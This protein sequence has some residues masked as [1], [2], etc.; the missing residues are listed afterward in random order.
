MQKQEMWVE[1]ESGFLHKIISFWLEKK[2][3]PKTLL[4]T[5]LLQLTGQNQWDEPITD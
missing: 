4:Q 5:F 2:I 1:A 3:L